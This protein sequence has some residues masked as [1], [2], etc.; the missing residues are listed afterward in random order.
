MAPERTAS[1][2]DL[3][4]MPPAARRYLDDATLIHSRRLLNTAAAVMIVQPLLL[5][6]LLWCSSAPLTHHL[7]ALEPALVY[8]LA[9]WDL[10]RRKEGARRFAFGIAMLNGVFCAAMGVITGNMFVTIAT[11]SAASA[12]I[13]L[14]GT[15]TP[16]PRA[17]V[18]A[19]AVWL[20]PVALCAA[21]L[22]YGRWSVTTAA[23]AYAAGDLPAAR[24]GL[25]RA[26]W[27]LDLRGSSAAEAGLIAFRRAELAL[28]EHDLASAQRQVQRADAIASSAPVVDGLSKA[29]MRATLPSR[30]VNGGVQR[31][32]AALYLAEAWGEKYQPEAD[33]LGQF[34]E[35][36]VD[37][38]TWTSGFRLK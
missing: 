29:D 20:I 37:R 7:L 21:A 16:H 4:A 11:A 30:I 12:V 13:L 22:L 9:A 27:V 17:V 15:R 35:H 19:I 5:L 24:T 34:Q 8:A 18:P 23:S 26:V 25:E 28:V 32:S 2:V 6:L 10:R 14:I 36:P 33:I 31:L 1:L 3:P 38:L